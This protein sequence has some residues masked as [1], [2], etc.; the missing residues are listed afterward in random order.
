MA[1]FMDHLFHSGDSEG[2]A[3]LS[4]DTLPEQVRLNDASCLLMFSGGR[5]S[6]VAALRLSQSGACSPLITLTSGHLRGLTN[7]RQ[8][9]REL[10]SRLPIET[11]W[12]VI[13]QPHELRTDTTFYKQT[14]LPCH[15]AY[16]VASAFIAKALGV[17]RIAFGYAAYQGKWPE[18]TPTAISALTRTLSKHGIELC[19]PVK[20]LAS[21]DAAMSELVAA[22]LS[23]EAL[24]QKCMRQVSNIELTEEVLIAQVAL[25]ERAI[26]ESISA[27]NSINVKVLI[28]TP[29][30]EL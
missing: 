7:V 5:D 6:T 4:L 20:D 1:G 15:H 17:K 8:R 28:N 12:I 30:G 18:Q 2:V 11:P 13:K 19:L 16:V 29:I 25:W 9:A 22:G 3:N 26:D 24:E 21:K 14:C 27:L 10:A 23:A